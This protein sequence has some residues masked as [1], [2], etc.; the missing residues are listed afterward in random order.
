M[1]TT[2]ELSGFINPSMLNVK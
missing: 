1:D 2:N